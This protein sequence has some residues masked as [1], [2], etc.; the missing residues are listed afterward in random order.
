MEN[1]FCVTNINNYKRFNPELYRIRPHIDKPDHDVCLID[2]F[3][4]PYSERYLV[5]NE[6]FSI[7]G[8]PC[9]Y[10]AT[11]LNIAWKEYGFRACTES[12]RYGVCDDEGQA[13]KN[14]IGSTAQHP[15]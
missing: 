6:R 2:L 4:I 9:L 12:E 5:K 11:S 13:Y 15:L 10:L 7:S 8:Q 1:D 3:H 14:D